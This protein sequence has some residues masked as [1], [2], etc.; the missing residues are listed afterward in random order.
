MLRES[1][2]ITDVQA[3][4]ILAKA[5]AA[6]NAYMRSGNVSGAD[7]NNKASKDVLN[8]MIDN[9][10]IDKYAVAR[11]T[12]VILDLRSNIQENAKTQNNWKALGGK[13]KGVDRALIDVLLKVQ[14]DGFAI[15]SQATGKMFDFVQT[16]K[17]KVPGGLDK[18]FAKNNALIREAILVLNDGPPVKGGSR[19][20]RSKDAQYMAAML[21]TANDYVIGRKQRAGIITKRL[22]N[23]DL[24]HRWDPVLLKSKGKEAFIRDSFERIDRDR[25]LSRDG[26]PLDDENLTILLD[27]AYNKIT[28]SRIRDL[29]ADG[30]VLSKGAAN[31]GQRRTQKSRE[32]HFKT[33][34]DWLEMHDQYGIGDLFE[35]A[36]AGI[37]QGAQEIALVENLGTDPL[38][39]FNS[40]IEENKI[41]NQIARSQGLK[42]RERNVFG[43]AEGMWNLLNGSADDILSPLGADIPAA[44]RNFQIAAKLPF[45]VLSNVTDQVFAG[46]D[47]RLWGSGYVNFVG[48]FLP[49]LFSKEAKKT[50]AELLVGMETFY[51]TLQSVARFGDADAVGKA[52]G[53]TKRL[54]SAVIRSSG[55]SA[56]NGASKRAAALEVNAQIRRQFS[57]TWENLLPGVK[58]GLEQGGFTKSDWNVTRK[59]SIT[60]PGGAQYIDMVKLLET[61]EQ[62][63]TRLLSIMQGVVR[64]AAPEPDLQVRAF[65]TAEGSAPGSF[66]G[67]AFRTFLQFKSFPITVMTQAVRAQMFDPRLTGLTSRLEYLVA[68]S[69]YATFVGAGIVQTKTFLAGKE[70]ENM[71]TPEFWTKALVQG[72]TIGILSDGAGILGA[73]STRQAWGQMIPPVF[74]MVFDIL[75]TL[76]SGGA[77]VWTQD[78]QEASRLIFRELKS[79]NPTNTFYT[80]L[81]VER[82]VIDQLE[83]IANPNAWQDRQNYER[84]LFNRTGQRYWWKPGDALPQ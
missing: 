73:T 68:T 22:D 62:V 3:D 48:K 39:T 81:I 15:N 4:E 26:T 60:K 2:T 5:K 83:N 64:T 13:D 12:Q 53:I 84:G 61:N 38:R 28:G 80:K 77:A 67:E 9:N 17:S 20:V 24:P 72:G 50:A 46:R 41:H 78:Y 70:P 7:I 1:K 36:L 6:E 21:R 65:T 56:L 82:L 49:Q 16:L 29:P 35:N 44:L 57:S 54:A 32:L 51:N 11:D 69:V 55:L 79:Q 45:A 10:R 74:S 18:L 23:Y 25:M 31:P 76:R 37:R 59:F 33:G 63:S 30:E 40:L 19:K 43:T 42:P 8:N 71:Q 14:N 52:S 27:N 75:T 58:L 47:M 66:K 34:E